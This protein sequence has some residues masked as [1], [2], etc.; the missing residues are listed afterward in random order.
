MGEKKAKHLIMHYLTRRM[1]V[2]NQ[3]RAIKGY[4][5]LTEREIV[6]MNNIKSVGDQ[7]GILV[8]QVRNM[9]DVEQRWVSIGQTNLQHGIMDLV[10]AIA[11]PTSFVFALLLLSGCVSPHK[12]ASGTYIK[13][14]HTEFRS[15]FGTNDSFAKLQRCKGPEF[16]VLF[17]LEADFKD[18]K[19][20]S[21]E[22]LYA[23]QHGYS[24]G[25]GG[26]IVEGAMNAGALGALAATKAGG[27]AAA[28][29][30]AVAIQSVTV[31]APKGHRR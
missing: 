10:R 6:A 9:P 12:E 23:W 7:L 20:L 17:Y 19:D 22:E 31:A 27:N 29:A 5:E 15:P 24:Q 18:C 21:P 16:F 8:Q 4:R 3:H 26:Q 13:T 11:K 28:S 2:D 14:Q 1:N 30:G 25:Q